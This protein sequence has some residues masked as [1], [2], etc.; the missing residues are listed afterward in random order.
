MVME[1]EG[2]MV[3][4]W[5]RPS[6]VCLAVALLHSPATAQT[7]RDTVRYTE[8][9]RATVTTRS[10]GAVRERR[11]VRDA[12]YRAVARGD[13]VTM[14]A[15]SI[16]LSEIEGGVTRVVDVDAVIGGRWVMV[17]RRVIERPF[18]PQDVAE[19][20]DLAIAMDDFLPPVPPPLSVNRGLIAGRTH[21]AEWRRLA[22]SSAL[23]RFRWTIDATRDTTILVADSV[24]LSSV[25]DRTESGNGTWNDNGRPIAWHREISSRVSSTVRG[26]T[27]H[28]EVKQLITV[29]REP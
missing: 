9:V 14:F 4:G 18:V 26:R 17:G 16:S 11:V 3:F 2:V 8:S 27:V 5:L 28:A 19:T 6:L 13:T 25:E 1:D 29:Q 12:S 15:D 7:A 24:P 20:S 21:H 22:D 10:G 23:A